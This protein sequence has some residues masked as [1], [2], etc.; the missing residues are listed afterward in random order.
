MPM[1][2]IKIFHRSRLVRSDGSRQ[3]IAAGEM[4]LPVESIADRTIVHHN[5]RAF[6]LT[7]K[8]FFAN[9]REEAF[10]MPV[11]R[12]H[13]THLILWIAVA[14][15]LASLAPLAFAL[16]SEPNRQT[17]R[18]L[19]GVKVLV[20]ELS[21]DIERLGLTKNQLAADT[22]AKLRKAGIKVLT[23]EECL[24]TPG[25]PYLYVNIN[26]NT[27]KPG[28]DKYSYSIDIGVIQ[29]VLLQRDTRVKSYSVTWSTG[30]VGVIEKEFVGRLR[31]SVDEVVNIFV[32][33]FYSVNP[34]KK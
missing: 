9:G 8:Q 20:E 26:I 11:A 17:L 12:I 32:S 23:Q 25:E 33:A 6:K 27:G 30:G 15:V 16:D 21:S 4:V 5:E 22:E 1:A 2:A 28:D 24:Q 13:R 29:N 19:Q 31:A 7:P 10:P 14:C 3:P 18:G 34:K